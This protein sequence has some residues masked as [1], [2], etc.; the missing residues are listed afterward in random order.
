MDKREYNRKYKKERY[1]LLKKMRICVECGKEDAWNGKTK[2]L[3]CLHSTKEASEKTRS[4]ES[5]EQRKIYLSRKRELCIAFGICRECLTREVVEGK[6][7]CNRCIVKQKVRYSN[8]TKLKREERTS[9]GLCYFCG[10]TAIEGKKTCLKHYEI[11]SNNLK[12]W[13]R[14]NKNHIWRSLDRANVIRVQK[15][16]QT[17]GDGFHGKIR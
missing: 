8:K 17:R 15:R 4:N 10:D 5:K 6:M 9:L 2:C 16:K 11:T 3:Q 1:E 12:K 14:D 7:R 13:N